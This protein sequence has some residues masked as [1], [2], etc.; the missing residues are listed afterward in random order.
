CQVGKL[1]RVTAQG[2]YSTTTGAN[3]LTIRLKFGNQI[4]TSTATAD[5]GAD[6]ANQ[7]WRIDAQVTCVAA[8]QHGAVEAQGVALL[9]SSAISSTGWSMPNTAPVDNINLTAPQ[10]L[11]VSA[12]WGT[13][14]PANTITLRQLL[15][16]ALGP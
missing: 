9:F 10:K 14:D 8:G 2:V 7:A 5:A 3:N 4:L 13:A 16:E 15:V 11:E 6:R 1:Y 12:Q